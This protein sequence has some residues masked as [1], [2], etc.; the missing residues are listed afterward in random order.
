MLPG[1]ILSSGPE[2]ASSAPQTQ[3]L[4]TLLRCEI[5]RPGKASHWSRLANLSGATHN[6]CSGISR[7]KPQFLRTHTHTHTHTHAYGQTH[8]HTHT[9][10]YT[11]TVRVSK[12]RPLRGL[13]RGRASVH[14]QKDGINIP[15]SIK[16]DL[17]LW[18]HKRAGKSNKNRK[19]RSGGKFLSYLFF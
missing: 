13:Q 8:T 15:V 9:C 4:S 2:P 1:S 16:K 14:R 10:T 6:G 5:K 3:T 19:T 18:Y 12:K 17:V 11:P 7:N